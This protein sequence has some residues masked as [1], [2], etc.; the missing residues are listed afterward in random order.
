VSDE[1]YEPNAPEGD[2]SRGGQYIS[3]KDVKVIF[4]SLAVLALILWPIYSLGVRNSEKA[5]CSSNM[6]AI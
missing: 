5:R 1:R 2:V 4:L 6:G 3:K